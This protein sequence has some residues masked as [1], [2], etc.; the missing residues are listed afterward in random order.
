LKKGTVLSAAAAA[1]AAFGKTG[2]ILM[3]APGLRFTCRLA[4]TPVSLKK[5][6]VLSAPR[7][8]G[9]IISGQAEQDGNKTAGQ[10]KTDR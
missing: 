10:N 6:T 4:A 3:Y 8:C 2:H 5:G 9:K 7:S 1:L